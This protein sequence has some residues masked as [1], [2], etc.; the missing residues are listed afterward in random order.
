[1]T[2]AKITIGIC[3]VGRMGATLAYSLKDQGHRL[4]T[5]AADRSEETKARAEEHGVEQLGSMAEVMEKSDYIFVITN[6][7]GAENICKELTNG[8]YQ[9][10]VIESNGL[11]GLESEEE[12]RGRYID[13]GVSYVDASL[14]G[15][16]HPGRDGYT[17]EHTIYLSGE[18]AKEVAELFGDSGYWNIEITD[19]GDE[20]EHAK[21]FRRYRNDR[22]RAEN[23][24]RGH[25]V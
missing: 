21:A 18:R 1:M 12:F 16:P 3:S 5:F 20:P 23:E 24:A 11:W 19:E 8:K 14:Y 22:E 25:P 10:C 7:D 15:W 9:G 17:N 2:E 4:V 6:G 13:A